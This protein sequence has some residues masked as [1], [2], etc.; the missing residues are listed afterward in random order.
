MAE[1]T[2]LVT[3]GSRGIGLAIAER[4]ARAGYNVIAPSRTE[5]DLADADSVERYIAT[6]ARTEIDV[7]INNAG[8]NNILALESIAVADLARMLAINVTA[9]FLLT[10]SFGA[11]MAERG[12]GHVVNISS[13]YSVLGR[14][15]RS[16]Y[17]TCKA[18]LNGATRA[19][20]IEFG[21]R[22]VIV[23]AVCPGFV[24]T[25]LTRKNNTPEV[26]AQLVSTV[27]LQ[28]LATAAEIADFVF[29]LGSAANTFVTAQTLMIDGG[30]SVQ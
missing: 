22:N 19:A 26:I 14:A 11:A 23:N 27:P 24:D 13:I 17:S 7:L 10:R 16:M 18:A 3:G 20:A 30:F 21:P 6:H 28:R 1:Q 8:E 25:D 12:R 4:Y 5:M 2:A 29:F 9:P 15:G